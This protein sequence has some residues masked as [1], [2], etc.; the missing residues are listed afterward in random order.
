MGDKIAVTLA[1]LESHNHIVGDIERG[2]KLY[3]R[4]DVEFTE[5]ITLIQ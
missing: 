2:I 5:D 4:G 3:E 1:T